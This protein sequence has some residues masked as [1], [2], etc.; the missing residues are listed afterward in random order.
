MA[1]LSAGFILYDERT[2]KKRAKAKAQA[3]IARW[4]H[5][6][7]MMDSCSELLRNIDTLNRLLDEEVAV[8]KELKERLYA[9]EDSLLDDAALEDG[10]QKA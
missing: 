7:K 1:V 4:E 10:A 2:A 5:T 6:E 9:L 8:N 3:E